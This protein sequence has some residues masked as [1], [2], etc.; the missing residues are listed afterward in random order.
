MIIIKEIQW[1][2]IEQ[3]QHKATVVV[4]P[5]LA[6]TIIPVWVPNL[7]AQIKRELM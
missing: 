3:C 5:G 1:L 6:D 4:Y 2:T 7:G